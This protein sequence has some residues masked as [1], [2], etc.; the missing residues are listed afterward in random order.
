M[1]GI[2]TD[3]RRVVL[4]TFDRDFDDEGVRSSARTL[5]AGLLSSARL[6]LGLIIR[7]RLGPLLHLLLRL[8]ENLWLVRALSLGYAL[9]SR[10]LL[11]HSDVRRLSERSTRSS[12]AVRFGSTL[13][14]SARYSSVIESVRHARWRP[15]RLRMASTPNLIVGENGRRRTR[16]QRPYSSGTSSPTP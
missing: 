15:L 16:P 2:D 12:S 8:G 7:R 4:H 5:I 11:P 13:E 3:T 10:R 1:H 6:C 14:K 9:L